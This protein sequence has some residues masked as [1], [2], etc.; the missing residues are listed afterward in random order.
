MYPHSETQW[1]PPSADPS[2]EKKV[3]TIISPVTKKKKRENKKDDMMEIESPIKEMKV[4]NKYLTTILSTVQFSHV[5][6]L[7]ARTNV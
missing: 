1:D 5:L 6:M 4:S 7:N 3:E 2:L